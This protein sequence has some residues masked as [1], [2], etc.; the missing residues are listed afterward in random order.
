MRSNHMCKSCTRYNEG[1]SF[2]NKKTLPY[3]FSYKIYISYLCVCQVISYMSHRY[4]NFKMSPHDLS[5][6]SRFSQGIPPTITFIFNSLYRDHDSNCLS[7]NCLVDRNLKKGRTKGH[8]LIFE[9][10]L[11]FTLD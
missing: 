4:H 8:N 6:L 10:F 9:E 5:F 2:F 11:S 7:T 1:F 3:F